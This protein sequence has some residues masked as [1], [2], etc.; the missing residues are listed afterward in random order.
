MI[1]PPSSEHKAQLTQQTQLLQLL[2]VT[3]RRS[4]WD[5]LHEEAL[6]FFYTPLIIVF[7][8]ISSALLLL[9]L[10]ALTALLSLHL[11]HILL[12]L[13]IG[14]I[15]G[16]AFT[17]KADV[18]SAPIRRSDDRIKLGRLAEVLDTNRIEY[19]YFGLLIGSQCAL[20]LC[21]H[22]QMGLSFEKLTIGASLGYAVDNF[23]QGA[24]GD[25]CE[26]YGFRV[27]PELKQTFWSAVSLSIFRTAA[28]VIALLLIRLSWQ[29]ILA[30][31][32][33]HSF[34]ARQSD[35]RIVDWLCS[36]SNTERSWM[37]TFF[38]EFLFLRI[39]GEYLAGHFDAVRRL[40][41]EFPRLKV[42]ENIRELF[43]DPEGNR[44]FEGYQLEQ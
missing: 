5:W 36:L 29:K 18:D 17:R 19:A 37:L 22:R 44:L 4:W 21:S 32:L 6:Q 39:T 3:L 8:I 7:F 42:N 13:S 26:L 33:I 10:F 40:T 20:L 15:F 23:M 30:R 24:L 38:D 28:S 35:Q 43:V 34:P 16:L 9:L 41:R 25:A 14:L 11:A 1:D 12:W 31:R 27:M 2:R